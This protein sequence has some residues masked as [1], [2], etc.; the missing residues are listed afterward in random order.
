MKTEQLKNEH[1]QE[2]DFKGYKLDDT[3]GISFYA[4]MIPCPSCF[5]KCPV[6]F[7]KG[8]QKKEDKEKREIL[9]ICPICLPLQNKIS[10][11]NQA[12]IPSRFGEVSLYIDN[13]K[14][15]ALIATYK[16][17]ISFVTKPNK[18]EGL[19]FSG[20][21]GCGKTT[22]VCALAK[23]LILEKQEACFFI[24]FP[25]LLNRIKARY[26]KQESETEFLE[27]MARIPVLILDELGKGKNSEW[28]M[29][30][31]DKIIHQRY[32]AKKKTIF[33]TNYS[34][35]IKGAKKREEGDEYVM[36]KSLQQRISTTS[37]SRIEEMCQF[38]EITGKNLRQKENKEDIII[39]E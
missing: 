6:C 23:E 15:P 31:I 39:K 20:E 33:T 8:Y 36:E 34:F 3:V 30:I 12:Q 19:L 28:E 38:I 11:F 16:K 24:E 2:C 17:A 22:L 14:Q 25:E 9:S 21:I 18:K 27:E 10:L 32:N 37:F 13:T 1:C 29:N 35:K 5:H 26:D 4:K 7:G